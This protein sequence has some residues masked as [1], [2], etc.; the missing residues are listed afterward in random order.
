MKIDLNSKRLYPSDSV[1]YLGVQI[2]NKLNGKSHDNAIS[3]ELNRVNSMLYKV[4]DFV[5]A[6]ILKSIY[7][8]LF[9][10]HITM[11][12]SFGIKTLAQL[13]VSAFSRKRNL[14][15]LILKSAMI[16]HLLYFIKPKLSKMQIESRLR[17]LSS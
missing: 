2:D 1:K 10:S 7:Y 14:K 6:N 16:S 8:A 9:E 11:L 12:A 15:L 4:R 5:N 17:T 13:T 3:T